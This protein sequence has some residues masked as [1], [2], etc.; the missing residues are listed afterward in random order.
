MYTFIE[1][2][3]PSLLSQMVCGWGKGDRVD[4]GPIHELFVGGKPF[5]VIDGLQLFMRAVDQNEMD[6]KM[7]IVRANL[8]DSFVK[9]V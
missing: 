7:R 6:W 8:G 1:A 5:A 4:L 2:R 9:L 3:E